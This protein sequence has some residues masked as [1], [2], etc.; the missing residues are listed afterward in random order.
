[1]QL[2]VFG[3][4]AFEVPFLARHIAEIRRQDSKKQ[5][6]NIMYEVFVLVL[7]KE[8]TEV[9]PRIAQPLALI[10]LLPQSSLDISLSYINRCR[11]VI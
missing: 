11:A 8:P 10:V 1:V 5:H 2:F 7:D 3:W 6:F 9:V 4:V